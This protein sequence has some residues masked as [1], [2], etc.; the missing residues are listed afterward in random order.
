MFLT[1]H[2]DVYYILRIARI[3]LV[4]AL[5]SCFTDIQKWL[6]LGTRFFSPFSTSPPPTPYFFLVEIL[7]ACKV[8]SNG[9]AVLGSEELGV[10]CKQ[11]YV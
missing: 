6:P 3:Q 11:K 9:R 10:E 4:N 1:P 7:L 2:L 5:C 8:N